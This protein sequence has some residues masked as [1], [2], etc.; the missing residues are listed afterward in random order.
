M[1]ISPVITRG[2]GS[3][4]TVNLVPTRGYTSGTAAPAA[5]YVQHI[6]RPHKIVPQPG[7]EYTGY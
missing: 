1:A 6:G 4:S 3:Y 2:Y 5:T 7:F